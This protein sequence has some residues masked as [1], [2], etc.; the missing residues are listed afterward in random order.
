MF[1][2]I[3]AA[4]VL[5]LASS[6]SLL[7]HAGPAILSSVTPKQGSSYTISP[8]AFPNLCVV[9]SSDEDGSTLIV[10][11]CDSSCET[12]WVFDGTAL[13]NA[14]FDMCT[15][16]TNGGAWSGNHPQ[17]WECF[18]N[19]PNQVWQYTNGQIKWSGNNFCFDLT[20]GVGQSGTQVQMWQC[21][22]HN[23]N[24]QWDL[25][26]ML[27]GPEGSASESSSAS[28][29][30]SASVAASAS[31]SASASATITSA[32][33][34]SASSIGGNLAA[35]GG[36]GIGIGVSIGIGHGHHASA[37]ASASASESASASASESA[38]ASMSESWAPGPSSTSNPPSGGNSN[39]DF[40]GYLQVSG[41]NVVDPS[42]NQVMLKGTN[43]G[44]WLVWEDWM[45]GMTDNSGNADRFA[46]TTLTSRFGVDQTYQLLNTW[47]DNW[48][49]ESDF[50]VIA[51]MGFNLI[52]LPFS[53]KNFIYPNGSYITNAQG[54]VDFSRLDWAVSNAKQ[55]GIYVI[56]VYHIWD[57]QEQG[58]STISENSNEGQQQRDLCGALWTKIAAHFAGESAI[59]AF[60]MINEPT[61]SWGNIL[62]QD[63]YT[64]IRAGDSKRIIVMESISSAPDSNWENVMY[65]MHEYNM[66]GEDNE[67]Y[68]QQQFWNGVQSSISQYNGVGVPAYIGEFMASGDTLT[69]MLQ[70]MNN[71]QVWWSGWTYKTVNM[72]RWGLLN[73]GGNNW[74]SVSGDSFDSL[75]SAWS[76][77]GST[78]QSRV[79]QN[80]VT[81]CGGGN[82]SKRDEIVQQ[83]T[84]QPFVRPD[85]VRSEAEPVVFSP[86]VRAPKI[87]QRVKR[88]AHAGRSRRM[89]KHGKSFGRI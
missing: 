42:G 28:D 6:R 76:N 70:Q 17:V 47:Q 83:R 25:T 81:A 30:A 37:S 75:Q 39:P 11:D 26:E 29:G 78:T 73:F 31:A 87:G 33:S 45:C 7:V 36:D 74:V 41:T 72:D 56:P 77:M 61:G 44:G 24:Q 4:A 54:D 22:S 89:A 9:P 51:S 23:E 16:A 53:Y 40:S 62:Q 58:Y 15:D 27:D 82:N 64:A 52:R 5:L 20:D 50:D 43:I 21:F 46:Q 13:K 66:M 80:Y 38:S 19:N 12:E 63:L 79:Y 85:T 10:V 84:V 60:D 18:S 35:G 55:R 3:S 67:G 2:T 34:A 86:R 71:D 69:W 59:A 49:V 68:N 88:T 32:P 8:A 57:G 1:P 48:F 14:A 65:S